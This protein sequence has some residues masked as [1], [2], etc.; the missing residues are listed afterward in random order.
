[1]SDHEG[2]INDPDGFESVGHDQEAFDARMK[3][4]TDE[5]GITVAWY[6]R[7]ATEAGTAYQIVNK[8][9]PQE[10]MTITI[11]EDLMAAII[12]AAAVG[13]AAA[14]QVGLPMP[15]EVPDNLASVEDAFMEMWPGPREAA[16][17]MQMVT[18][19][20]GAIS[21]EGNKKQ[22][23]KEVAKGLK[24]LETLTP[25]DFAKKSDLEI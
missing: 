17:S 20:A 9:E 1:M 7:P 13:V 5:V 23:E 22:V 24:E 11:P 25:A 2:F 19:V 21:N 4:F 8:D 12:K 3:A 18:L 15:G 6:E 16:I 10:M 14:Y